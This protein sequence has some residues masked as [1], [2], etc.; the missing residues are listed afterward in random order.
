MTADMGKFGRF[1]ELI[2]ENK[3]K[4]RCSKKTWISTN[5]VTALVY[6]GR[7]AF[8]AVVVHA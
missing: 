1:D 2:C 8:Q 5:S 4:M 6:M 7:D 3:N